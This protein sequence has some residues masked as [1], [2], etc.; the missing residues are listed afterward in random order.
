M[1]FTQEPAHGDR[2]VDRDVHRAGVLRPAVVS[3]H[4]QNA[5]PVD[6]LD[7]LEVRRNDELRLL[8]QPGVMLG[9]RFPDLDQRKLPCVNSTSNPV[10]T[11]REVTASRKA[12]CCV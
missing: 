6:R 5:I 9:R 11:V 12:N 10:S 1:P 4:S 8:R 7:R 3:D 2:L